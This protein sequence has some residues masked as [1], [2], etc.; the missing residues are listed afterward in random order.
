MVRLGGYRAQHAKTVDVLAA[1]QRVTLLVV[2]P[3]T[4]A[5]AAHDALMTAG[6]RSNTDDVEALLNSRRVVPQIVPSA[7]AS[8]PSEDEAQ[9]SQQRRE[10]EGGHL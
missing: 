4:P 6:H 3:E 8:A 5:Q 9:S 7:G 2:P 1:R 10:P